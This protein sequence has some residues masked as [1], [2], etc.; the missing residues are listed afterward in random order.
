[1]STTAIEPNNNPTDLFA[2][3]DGLNSILS[4]SVGA[5]SSYCLLAMLMFSIRVEILSLIKNIRAQHSKCSGGTKDCSI[6]EDLKIFN[7]K[8][9]SLKS[10]L[11]TVR[12]KSPS[13]LAWLLNK[14]CEELECLIEDL[15][16]STDD[17]IRSLILQIS[18]VACE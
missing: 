18:E 9:H 3:I 12:R 4:G 6:L 16:F 5:F 14:P 2:K 15:N 10:R 8:L 13:S 7:I 1:M 17:D 11:E